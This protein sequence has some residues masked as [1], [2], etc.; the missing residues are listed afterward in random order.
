MSI[1]V[2]SMSDAQKEYMAAL[3]SELIDTAGD[4]QR[5]V[6]ATKMTRSIMRQMRQECQKSIVQLASFLQE[7]NTQV[8][9]VEIPDEPHPDYCL[10]DEC[11]RDRFAYCGYED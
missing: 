6:P 10:C 11:A 1:K 4:L 8:E 2:E 3:L 9:Q 5:S 7:V